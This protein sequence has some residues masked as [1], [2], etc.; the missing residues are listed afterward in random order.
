MSTKKLAHRNFLNGIINTQKVLYGVLF[1][2]LGIA[3]PQIFHILGGPA[4]GTIFSPMHLPVLITGLLLGPIAGL[5]VGSVTPMLSY[6]I[7][8]MPHVP[9]MYIMVFELGIYGLTAG[10]LYKK[11]GCRIL[12]SILGAL[13]AGRLIYA[14]SFG[15]IMNTPIFPIIKSFVL[16]G[17]PGLLLQ[18]ALIP[19]LVKMLESAVRGKD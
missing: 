2:A 10:L 3:V 11:Y 1:I 17:L 18:I 19:L 12:V 9:I 6:I 8:G 7:Y 16:V 5:Y 4:A 13:I 14:V 15:I